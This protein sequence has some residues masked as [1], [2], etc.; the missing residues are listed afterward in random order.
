MSVVTGA[1]KILSINIEC[2]DIPKGIIR[3]VSTP[4]NGS[5][6]HVAYKINR[7]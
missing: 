1:G 6:I 7:L 4:D 3:T 2:T 5:A